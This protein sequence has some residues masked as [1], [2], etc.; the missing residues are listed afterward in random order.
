MAGCSIPGIS[1][2]PGLNTGTTSGGGKGLEI[3]SFTAEPSTIYSRSVVRVIMDVENQGGTTAKNTS[4]FAFLTGSNINLTNRSGVYW[5]GK[6]DGGTDEQDCQNF[7]KDLKPADVVKG[8]TGDSK[9]VTWNVVAPNVTAGQTRTDSFIGRV[10]TDYQT[11]V[12]GNIW[13]Y[14]ETESD[15]AKASGRSLNRASFASTSGPVS[16]VVSV[17]PDPVIVYESG[18]NSA[19]LNIRISNVASGTIYSSGKVTGCSKIALKTDDLNN[20]TYTIDAPDFNLADCLS[21]DNVEL[22]SGKPTTVF[23]TIT[24]KATTI[25]AF[26]SFPI[27]INVKY[28]YYTERTTTVTVQGK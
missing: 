11:G 15:A 24:P 23:C 17:S 26:K 28:G 16:V 19:T 12:N 4:S 6:T 2:I 22:V 18:D 10:Y 27:T 5:Y 21:T 13:V 3:T 8:T 14:S 9:T 1:N 7:T 25:T 20:V